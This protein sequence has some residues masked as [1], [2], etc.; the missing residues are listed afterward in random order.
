VNKSHYGE[1]LQLYEI[2][3]NWINFDSS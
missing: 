3:T 2:L 1:I